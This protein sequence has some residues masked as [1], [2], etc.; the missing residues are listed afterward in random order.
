MDFGTG[1]C[2]VC[3]HSYRNIIVFHVVIDSFSCL[4][5]QMSGDYY[6]IVS[7]VT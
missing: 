6:I 5:T 7:L 3:V 1:W 2:I 4:L